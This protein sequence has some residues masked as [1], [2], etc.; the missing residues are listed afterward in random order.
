M[1]KCIGK[2]NKKI[3]IIL[4][5]L[6]FFNTLFNSYIFYLNI[7]ND[8]SRVKYIAKIIIFLIYLFFAINILVIVL[9]LIKFYYCEKDNGPKNN[10]K[11]IIEEEE[12]NLL[13][14]S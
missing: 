2:N 10:S 5:I 12:E 6:I 14:K 9:P 3:F 13:S 11:I 8:N 1:N 4:L 7:R